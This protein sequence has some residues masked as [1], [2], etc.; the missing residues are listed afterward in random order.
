M[1]T[2]QLS[3]KSFESGPSSLNIQH[4]Y[5]VFN[6]DFKPKIRRRS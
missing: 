5:R 2:R 3:R 6:D 1:T 4:D